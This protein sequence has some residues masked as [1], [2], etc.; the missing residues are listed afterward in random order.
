MPHVGVASRGRLERE[1]EGEG[2][3]AGE[4]EGEGERERASAIARPW[5]PLPTVPP[6]P[7]CVPV[8]LAWPQLQDRDQCR[9]CSRHLATEGCLAGWKRPAAGAPMREHLVSRTGGASL[10]H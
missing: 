10:P 7:R 4:G 2:E 3:G 1:G 6:T 9:M 5:A 8:A